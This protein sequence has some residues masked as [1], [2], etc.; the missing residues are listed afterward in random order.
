[1]EY[2]F[3]FV[4]LISF[5]FI[6]SIFSLGFQCLFH[7]EKRGSIVVFCAFRGRIDLGVR[8]VVDTIFELETRQYYESELL[9]TQH[10]TPKVK[11][12]LLYE[13]GL[14]VCSMDHTPNV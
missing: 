5:D 9:V 6:F 10:T 4:P 3:V 13:M 14:I 2:S 8:I 7:F 1:V 12:Y 11:Q